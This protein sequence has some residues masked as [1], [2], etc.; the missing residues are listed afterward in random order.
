MRSRGET[1]FVTAWSGMAASLIEGGQTCHSRY[2]LPVLFTENSK[3]KIERNS[4]QWK[5]L[6]KHRVSLCDEA[7]M[8]PG[9]FLIELD[10]MLREFTNSQVCFGGKII[11]L[12]GDF[13]QIL[14]I[15]PGATKTAIISECVNQTELFGN[16][17]IHS[18]TEL[19]R[20]KKI[21]ENG[22]YNLAIESYH[23]KNVFPKIQL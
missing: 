21:F 12:S 22:Y 20:K 16:F 10:R 11:L 7:S 23:V 4:P 15:K 2:D 18:L 14:P 1:I 5:A 17:E 19:T 13:P 8:M 6:N 3:T 9:L